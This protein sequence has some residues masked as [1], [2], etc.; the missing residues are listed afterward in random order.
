MAGLAM[1]AVP[2]S[3][4]SSPAPGVEETV[5][6]D[7]L[8]TAQID[9]V[10]WTQ[11]IV[12]NT[13]FVGGEFTNAR[14]A[15]SAAGVNTSARQNLM[16]YNLSTGVMTSWNPGANGIVRSISA[17]PDGSRIYVA[18]SF[19]NIAGVARNRVA[20]FDATTGNIL[21]WNPGANSAVYDI[22]ARGNTVW[23]TGIF[24]SAAGGARTKVAAVTA[25][26]GA[27]LPF[28]ADVADGSPRAIVVSPDGGKVVIAGGFTS[29][30]GSTNPGRGMAALNAVTGAS[31]QWA[32]NSLIR[33]AGTSAGMYDLASDNDSVYGVGWSYGGTAEDGFEGTFRANWSDGSL[34]WLEDCHGDNYS[35]AVTSDVVYTASHD[36]YCGNV[37][38]FPQTPSPWQLNHSLAFAK[39]YHGK[40]LTN[41]IYGYKSYGGQPAASL[42]HW[43]PKWAVGTYTGKSQATWTVQ[44]NDNYVVY[45]GE[46][47]SVN[48]VAQQG[49][50]RFAKKALAPKKQGPQLSNT[51]FPV[52]ALSLRAGEVRVS[53]NANYDKD[54][55]TLTYQL[56]RQGTSLPIYETTAASNFWTQPVMKFTDKTVTNGQT[57]QYRIRATDPDGNAAT[58]AWTSV[59]ASADSA[60][61]Y[62][63]GVIDD[64]A[65]DYWPLSEAS[66]T[67]G[68]N[69]AE[70]GD[71][72]VSNGTRGVAGPNLAKSSKSTGFAG[73]ENSY[74]TSTVRETA[75]DTFTVEAWVNT[76]STRGGKIVGFGNSATASSNNYDRHVYMSADGTINFGVHPGSVRTVNSSGGFNDGAWHYIVASMDSSGMKLYVDGR[77][78]GSRA[79]T[80]TG[81]PF[82]GY[83]HIGGDNTGGWP[84]VTDQYLNGSISDVA[85]Y[86]ESLSRD[87]IN[88]HWIN[89]GR[90]S[91]ITPAPAD[92]YG[93]SVYELSPTIY[94]R[95]NESAG[96]STAADSGKDSV[97]GAYSGSIGFGAPGVIKDVANSAISLSPNGGAQTGIASTQAFTNP[98]TFAVETWF[99][100][101]STSGGKLVGFGDRNVGTSGS[102]DRHIYMSGDGRVKFGTYNGNLNI[103]Q[104]GTGYNDNK[105]HYVVGQISASGMQ[106]YVDG[107]LVD[108]NGN[109]QSQSYNGY[110]RAG[111]DSGWEGD[112]YFRGSL[113]EIAIYPAPLTPEQV[114]A[115]YDLARLGY[116]NS[117]PVA[118]FSSIITDL[119]VA[120]DGSTSSDVEGP[121]A[122]YSW[123]FGDGQTATGAQPSHSF[124]RSG[125][126]N[127]SLIVTD[128]QGASS[129]ITQP[130][131]VIGANEL[132]TAAFTSTVKH[133]AVTFDATS[134]ADT[135]GTIV[136]YAWAFG[137]GETATG[138]TTSHT[139]ATAGA[140]T[141]T[142]T[143]TDDRGDSSASQQSV[144]TTTA[145]SAP[146]DAYGA[147]VFNLAP[148][149]YWRLGETSGSVAR[150]ASLEDSDGTYYGN[151][152]RGQVG[153]LKNV[154]NTAIGTN[155]N[156]DVQTGVASNKRFVNPTTFTIESWFK[157]DSTSGGKIVGFGNAQQ[158]WS[159]SYDRHVYMSGDGRVK[160][161]VW[162][163]QSQ[164][165]ESAP[166]FNDNK[167]HQV[168]AQMSSSGMKLY[169]DGQLISSNGNSDAQPYDGYWRVGGDSGWEGDG[170]WRGSIDEVAVYPTVLTA[171]QVATHYQLGNVGFVNQPPVASFVT[172]GSAMTVD[173]DGT[174]SSDLDGPIASYSWNFGDGT[175]G[176]GATVSHTYAI[177]GTFQ[178]TLT[179]TD[180][181]GV[182]NA[183]THDVT[184]PA[185][186][187]LPTAAFVE[188]IQDLSVS[189]DA[190][191]S[192]DSDGTIVSYA[193][194]FGDG[195]TSTEA[196]PIHNYA[197]GG[198]FV[199]TLTVTDDRGGS[200]KATKQ[201]SLIA[202]NVAPVAAFSTS[203][204]GL[205]VFTNAS[206]STDGDG[207]VVSYI[208][209]FG[210]GATAT[211]TTSTASHR[212]DAAGTYE[213][214]LTVVDDDGANSAPQTRQVVIAPANQAPVAAFTSSASGLVLSVDGATSSDPDGTVASYAWNFGDGGTATGAQ[215]SR[216]YGAA[217][218]YTVS[219]TVTDD[220]GATNTKTADVTVTAP[221]AGSNV[222]AKDTFE[223]AATNGWGSADQGG[224]WSV[225]LASRFSVAGGVGK[226]A[227]T[228]GTSPVATLGSV[229]SSSARVTAEFSVDK[230]AEG[231]YVTVIGRQV[232]SAQ[233]A[234]RVRLAADGSV[235]L[236]MLEGS[237]GVGPT[238]TP[239]LKVVAGEKYTVMFEVTGTAPSTL[240]MKLWKSTDAEPGAWAVT[241]TNTAAA[242]Q[243]PGSVG[244]SSFLPSGAA[245]SAPVALTIDNLSITD[246]KVVVA[247]ANQAPV[248]AFTSSASGL[249]LSVDG[250][251]S[252]DPDGTVASY[253]WNFGDGGTATGAQASRTYGAAGTYTVSL[254]VTDDKGATNTK[255]AAVTVAAAPANQAPVAAFTSSASGL[256]LSVDG[257][258]SSDPDGT[259]A[260]YAWNFG[261]GGTATGAQASRTY[262]AAGTYTVS[263]TV[264]DD[265]GATNTKTADVTVTAPPAGSNVLAKDTFERAATNGWGS[266]DQGGAWSVNLASRFSVAGGVGKVAVTTGTSPVATLGSV[267]S[268]S[269]RVTAEFSVDKLAEG[270]YVTVIGRQVGSAQYAARVRLAADGSVKLNMLEGSNGVG[271]TVTPTLKVVAGEKYT[272]MFEVTGT[273]PSTLSMKLWKST[274]AEPGA[275]AVTRTNTAAALQVPGS[276][277]LSSFL[278]SG[279]AASAPV[280]LTI[281]N[282]SI[283]DPTIP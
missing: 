178:A 142:L 184:A 240:S 84:G 136:S 255:T 14:P 276:V 251:T 187:K 265:K 60:S 74:A 79:D 40:T 100:T 212:Y 31:E 223:R 73:A 262:G 175:T 152:T 194:D 71:V 163:G 91:T 58:G 16:S 160:F 13:V 196:A 195:T 80:T 57:Y 33:N 7:P 82:D 219:L 266:A 238:V 99:K 224:A 258:T 193:W 205:S 139:Y 230:L 165:L 167:W 261:D 25:S 191:A 41:D 170:Y 104:S 34:V 220:K 277:G 109:T 114:G 172:S 249:V 140:Y 135:D 201:V 64:G 227:V 29:V 3:A 1:T 86:G 198:D 279:A 173:F 216:T 10:A 235:K 77:L 257:A 145:P 243:V 17:S 183:V 239:T 278:P 214:S 204:I 12:G 141:V 5:T 158:G 53:W 282:L 54:N 162:T 144:Q 268:S 76:T 241:R 232:G 83:W 90:A 186:N 24:S 270:Q 213:V 130:V 229:S 112:Q 128:G 269:A 190:T 155:P 234:A 43:Y 174:A 206:A 49:L 161:G 63:L 253:A 281:D 72:N 272:V 176:A 22:V 185:P 248:A 113:D 202:P 250:A 132:P 23:Y 103:I 215:A 4:D 94:W 159:S 236:N 129:T 273:A 62:S 177:A 35:V 65:K 157:T 11:A 180:G 138:Q 179:V 231:Q 110:W 153:A 211:T 37:G 146:T 97:T 47:P 147:S 283:T 15:G 217:G 192:S 119:A 169:I 125:T 133:S 98:T 246:P 111:G 126:Y 21:P 32:V 106:L 92:A 233:Y 189:L 267:S 121:I 88:Q 256:V 2:A 87:T 78:V 36:H 120:F 164:I 203:V 209:S 181:Q 45:G 38:G 44:A 124:P 208:W 280:A 197:R 151:V 8:P 275:W 116:V 96:A 123:N 51:Q 171:S 210:D 30:N 188:T 55:E 127:V 131:S 221:P 118:A 6:A 50:V 48:N 67:I 150:D 207:S 225:N 263:L 242:L 271:P 42:L 226:V 85:V 39:T 56:Y 117:K 182:T 46:F 218:T 143:V 101:D 259:V 115:H 52:S 134:S 27:L 122:S 137:D 70:G 245:A 89:S 95:A 149:L 168:V 228:T 59:Q 26:T 28:S 20:A 68:S 244:L 148:S 166:G 237:N 69:W 199:I 222:L 75:P 9:G 93:K 102:Y 260:S 66:G 274:D 247:P 252:S 61:A 19:T 105:W 200:A 108:S 81:Q 254:M 156:G 18:G 264:T 107:N 154:A